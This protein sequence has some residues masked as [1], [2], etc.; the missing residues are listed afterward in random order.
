MLEEL[1][2]Q[3]RDCGVSQR[4]DQHRVPSS[5]SM[6]CWNMGNLQILIVK[7]MPTTLLQSDVAHSERKK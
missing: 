7:V 2:A 5:A 4:P 6:I 1:P 3:P